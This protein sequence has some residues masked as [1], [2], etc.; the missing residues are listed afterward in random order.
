MEDKVFKKSLGDYRHLMTEAIPTVVGMDWISDIYVHGTRRCVELMDQYLPRGAS[1]LDF[2]CGMGL[3]TVLLG[4]LG[5][6]V[7]GMDIDIGNQASL[8]PAALEAP[9]GSMEAEL[10]YPSF[11]GDCWNLLSRRFGNEFIKFD[12]KHVPVASNSLDGVVSHAVYEHI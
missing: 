6:R 3:V 5:F 7:T 12:G 2:G 8:Q 4:K 10:E 9:W 11:L 1:V